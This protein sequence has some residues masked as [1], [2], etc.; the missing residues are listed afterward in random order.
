M[1]TTRIIAV[2]L[3]VTLPLLGL[4]MLTN[5]PYIDAI[6]EMVI[7]N[8]GRANRRIKGEIKTAKSQS[9]S[10]YLERQSDDSNLFG[11]SSTVSD[12]YLAVGDPDANRVVIYLRQADNSWLRSYEINQPKPLIGKYIES[13]FG[14]D[15]KLNNNILIFS[16]IIY[17]DFWGHDIDKRFVKRKTYSALLGDK[18]TQ[19]L[20]KIGSTPPY[21]YSEDSVFLGDNVALD[22][23]DGK[24]SYG[25]GD[26]SASNRYIYL[27]NPRTGKKIKEI[28]LPNFGDNN[29]GHFRLTMDSNGE[30]LFVSPSWP[31]P[32]TVDLDDNNL[33][34]SASR[35]GGLQLE[36]L[37]LITKDGNLREI[38][39]P[40]EYLDSIS[41]REN[42]PL[43]Y[44]NTIKEIV[45]TNKLLAI[46]V[47]VLTSDLSSKT[48]RT[49]WQIYPQPK[50]I[51]EE[52]QNR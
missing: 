40:V 26:I 1:K 27:I 33:A 51:K 37:V 6:E 9:K 19:S 28:K 52:I 2:I 31:S 30:N 21:I 32:Q 45:I 46:T 47:D 7:D 13:G 5:Q 18:R 36:P 25:E 24:N 42:A 3:C 49:F 29:S 14:S 8:K 17:R 41:N 50:L 15:L 4:K 39:F 20:R 34:V 38:E 22:V 44:P 11:S 43:L 23:I 35:R 10:S 16:S 48:I 12:K